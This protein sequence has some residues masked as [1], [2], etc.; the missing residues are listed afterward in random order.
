MQLC[1]GIKLF[2]CKISL[3]AYSPLLCRDEIN[4]LMEIVHSRAIDLPE[5]E[6]TNKHLTLTMREGAKHPTVALENPGQLIAVKQ[7]DSI[8]SL[9]GTSSPILKSSVCS[10][11]LNLYIVRCQ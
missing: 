9:P 6:L 1:A 3:F 4:R 5:V 11:I 2:T 8:K 10:S 7:D